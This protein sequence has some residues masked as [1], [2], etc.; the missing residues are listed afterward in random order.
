[1]KVFKITDWE[2]IVNNLQ[3]AVFVCDQDQN[4]VWANAKLGEILGKKTKEVIGEKCYRLFHFKDKPIEN[5]PVSKANSFDS[6]QLLE[7]WEPSLNKQLSI[8]T[9]YV[10]WGK[11]K[12][13]YLVHTV[14]DLTKIRE[15]EKEL[16]ARL[17]ELRELNLGIKQL[18]QMKS[19]FVSMV[20]HELRTPMTVIKEAST[21]LLTRD[22]KA[23][24]QKEYLSMICKHVNRLHRLITDLLDLSRI[25]TG[26]LVLKQE[27]LDVPRLM[28]ELSEIIL[29][30]LK[31]KEI[32]FVQ[33]VEKNLPLVVGDKERFL[34]VVANLIGNAIK[35]TP[36]GGEV[37][38]IISKEGDKLIVKVI[39]NGKGLTPEQMKH[40]FE[41]FY[42]GEE[43]LTR[44]SGGTG[45]GL[46]IAKGLVEVMGGRIWGTS[47]GEGKGSM[48]AFSLPISGKM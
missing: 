37:N 45:L 35:Y 21:L 5:C 46:T 32:V 16:Q 29:P 15:R 20:S 8:S 3:E 43:I 38:L 24:K 26:K 25:G 34:Q 41:S 30:V 12:R 7:I 9:N 40:V 2:Q 42:V 39:D 4:I 23:E 11:P 22:V 33:S 44:A 31:E 19:D 36:R 14:F 13:W 18:E 17:D 10:S 27:P 48:F 1:M 6:A 47:E 28:G